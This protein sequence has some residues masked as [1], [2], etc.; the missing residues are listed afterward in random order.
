MVRY[1][2]LAVFLVCLAFGGLYV[3]REWIRPVTIKISQPKE[4]PKAGMINTS[5]SRTTFNFDGKYRLTSVKV[6][7]SGAATNQPAPPLWHLVAATGSLPV[8]RIVY[9]LPIPG[10]QPAQ[11]NSPPQRLLPEIGYVLVLEAG[12]AHGQLEFKP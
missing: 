6:I 7:R 12:K 10:M 8:D 11:S 9:G 3:Y 4:P 1:L 5:G 2:L